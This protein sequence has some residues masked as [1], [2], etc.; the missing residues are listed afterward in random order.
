MEGETEHV[1]KLYK[2]FHNDWGTGAE[3]IFDPFGFSRNKRAAPGK[4]VSRIYI[5]H[6]AGGEMKNFV[7][8]KKEWVNTFPLNSLELC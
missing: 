7:N 2:A 8:L 3:D 1:V 4:E 5:E 6:C